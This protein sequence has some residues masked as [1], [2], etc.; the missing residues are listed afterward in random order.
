MI[1]WGS[2]IHLRDTG[3]QKDQGNDVLHALGFTVSSPKLYRRN[4]AALRLSDF[5][6]HN[7]KKY[8]NRKKLMIMLLL[9]VLKFKNDLREKILNGFMTDVLEKNEGAHL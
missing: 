1:F 9:N 3:L 2:V 6:L 7:L 8:R 4:S 5:I